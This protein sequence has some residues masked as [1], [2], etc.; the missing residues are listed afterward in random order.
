MWLQHVA[1]V[2]TWRQFTKLTTEVNNKKHTFIHKKT[3]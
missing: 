2:N 3:N 1:K